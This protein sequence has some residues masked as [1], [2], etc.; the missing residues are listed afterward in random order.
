[1]EQKMWAF[2]MEAN[3]AKIVARFFLS[4]WAK[5]KLF[6]HP[7]SHA[8]KAKLLTLFNAFFPLHPNIQ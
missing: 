6:L 5:M 1:M 2:K 3:D 4:F 8:R 7:G